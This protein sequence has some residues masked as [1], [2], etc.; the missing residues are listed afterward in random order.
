MNLVA[1][2][3][4]LRALGFGVLAVLGSKPSGLHWRPDEIELVGWATRQ[5]GLDLHAL[6]VEQLE[7]AAA[8]LRHENA[9][10]RSIIPQRA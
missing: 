5:V 7:A 9:T 8:A 3:L 1:F 2:S 4:L 6:K 10:L